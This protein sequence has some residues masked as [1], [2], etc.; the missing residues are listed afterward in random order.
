MSMFRD[1][2]DTSPSLNGDEFSQHGFIRDAD[3]KAEGF[4]PLTRKSTEP[5]LLTRSD[6][7]KG[8]TRSLSFATGTGQKADEQSIWES[9]EWVKMERSK[10]KMMDRS[11]SFVLTSGTRSRS[12]TASWIDTSISIDPFSTGA[13]LANE[14]TKAGLKCARV[15][16]IWDSPVANGSLARRNKYL[17]GEK[18][19]D[20]GVRAVKQ[21]SC[22]SL[23][24]LRDFLD[25]LPKHPFKCVVKPVQS[26]GTDDV[27]LCESYEEA[28]TAFTR[29]YGKVNGLGL[30]NESALAQEFLAGKEFVIDKVS[31]SGDHK[32]VAIWEYDKRPVN[33]ANFILMRYADEVL[34]A[35]GILEGPSHME[36]TWLDIARE[37]IGYNQVEVTLDAYLGGHGIW[38]RISSSRYPMHKYGRDVDLVNRHG[39][40]VR[41]LVG[42]KKIRALESFRSISWEVKPGDYAP[43]T[44]DCY[45]RPG[46]VQIVNKS[47][48][49]V[50]KDFEA[51]HSLEELQLIDYSVICKKPPP[52]GAVVVVDAF[53]TGA[54]LA[55]MVSDWGYKLVMVFSEKNSPIKSLV[56]KGANLDTTLVITHDNSAHDQE[57]AI[58]STLKAMEECDAPV[59][60]VIPGTETGVELAEIL[61]KRL[62]TRTNSV[63]GIRQ[64]REKNLM[65]SKVQEAGLR[66]LKQKLCFMNGKQ[67]SIGSTNKGALV[68]EFLAGTEYALDGVSRDGVYKVTAIW[69]FDKISCNGS[70]FVYQGM[71]LLDGNGE[72]ETEMIEYA[73]KVNK[74]LGIVQGPSHTELIFDSEGPC[75]IKVGARFHGGEGTWITCAN[76]CIGYTQVD[77]CLTCY[78]RPDKYDE[79]PQFP[80]LK[81]W[82]SEAFLVT[83]EH[84]VGPSGKKLKSIPG[85]DRIAELSSFRRMELLTQPGA[86][87]LPTIDYFTRPGS[88]S[89]VSASPA[90]LARDYEYIRTL[91]DEGLF[92][93]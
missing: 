78:L 57:A 52:I 23:Q 8:R 55:A 19:R 69:K 25:T 20:A 40:I 77:A 65:Q 50:D 67:S 93:F 45:T 3:V 72:K 58:A 68:Q 88:V 2:P 48:E 80:T 56:S 29:I 62:Q 10:G 75:L 46:C 49:Q 73:S 47:E 38:S 54:N 28:E 16:S 30:V 39:G 1:S 24:Q 61:S 60:A 44:I 87:L 6:S 74:A 82:G 81:K 76:E 27:F 33:D 17:M 91:E 32:C 34:N 79:I 21:C 15:L 42:E 84:V 26:A 70:D 36:G 90:E 22:T 64:R 41:S 14:V 92:S 7:G 4:V 9:A 31:V 11:N 51:L 66:S 35:L 83:R 43:L 5:S 85:V 18:V 63:T 59:M 12:N 53:S 86:F 13:H 89:L 37:C 71:H